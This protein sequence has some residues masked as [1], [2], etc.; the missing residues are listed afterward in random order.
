LSATRTCT[1]RGGIGRGLPAY[2]L[3]HEESG[4]VEGGWARTYRPQSRGDSL[5]LNV[6]CRC[7]ASAG[8]AAAAGDL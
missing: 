2:L 6:A 1:T 5:I 7:A 8:P 3:G 4:V